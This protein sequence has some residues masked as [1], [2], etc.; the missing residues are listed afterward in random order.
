MFIVAGLVS[1]SPWKLLE[2]L[3]EGLE[4]SLNFIKTCLYEP[5][6]WTLSDNPVMVGAYSRNFL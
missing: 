2:S 1:L 3:L 5:W 4:K 6:K